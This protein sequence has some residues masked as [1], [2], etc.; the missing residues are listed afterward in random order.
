MWNSWK[1]QVR[2]C[3]S[4]DKL[5]CELEEYTPEV[6]I[7]QAGTSAGQPFPVSCS[8]SSSFS[9]FLLLCS[10]IGSVHISTPRWGCLSLFA[11][12]WAYGKAKST[13]WSYGESG[14]VRVLGGTPFLT[15]FTA[16]GET[17]HGLFSETKF[18][19]CHI[20]CVHT[21][22]LDDLP[23]EQSGY[24]QTACE[25]CLLI[26]LVPEPC[27]CDVWEH[28]S[29]HRPKVCQ[30]VLPV[31]SNMQE[32]LSVLWPRHWS[33]SV[34]WCRYSLGGSACV[35]KSDHSAMTLDIVE[36]QCCLSLLCNWWKERAA[37][38]GTFL[39]TSPV[40]TSALD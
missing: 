31:I 7:L 39:H 3:R 15:M 20:A 9:C 29:W 18:S 11:M 38:L 6:L 26:M 17:N 22:Q 25:E 10:S 1:L 32:R 24:I 33:C 30:G 14:S 5:L 21:L 16:G 2:T 35:V 28:L 34:Y 37:G 19:W 12:S 8:F 27:W 36:R 13:L 4:T 23:P 40:M